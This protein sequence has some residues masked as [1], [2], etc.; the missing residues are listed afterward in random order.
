VSGTVGQAT[1]PKPKP[2]HKQNQRKHK[3]AQPS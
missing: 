1:Q 3:L 2:P